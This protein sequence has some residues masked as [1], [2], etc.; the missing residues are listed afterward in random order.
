MQT[1]PLKITIFSKFPQ[2]A[3]RNAPRS[4]PVGGMFKNANSISQFCVWTE[5]LADEIVSR[6][7]I[8]KAS[9]YQMTENGANTFKNGTFFVFLV[10]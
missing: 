4:Q 10:M 1:C 9:M 5:G 8:R 7:D 3:R 2:S 6:V